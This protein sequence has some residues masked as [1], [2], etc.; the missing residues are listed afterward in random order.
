MTISVYLSDVIASYL[1]RLLLV[2]NCKFYPVKLEKK[3]LE[4]MRIRTLWGT[5][6]YVSNIP[7]QWG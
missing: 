6:Q 3:I 1:N 4:S 2:S 5:N 7:G